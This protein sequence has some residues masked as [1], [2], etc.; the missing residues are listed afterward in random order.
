MAEARLRIGDKFDPPAEILAGGVTGVIGRRGTGKSGYV[1]RCLEELSRVGIPFVAFDPAG[2][3]WGIRSSADGKSEGYPVLVI[4]GNNG[5]IPLDK[6]K[7]AALAHKVVELNISVVIDISAYGAETYRTFVTAFCN[8]LFQINDTLRH[9]VLEEAPDLVPQ[10]L[11]PDQKKCYAAVERLVR[12]GRNKDLGVTLVSQRAATVNKDVLSQ[13]SCLVVFGLISPQDRKALREWVEAN[14]DAAMLKEFYDGLASLKT[15]EAWA[16]WPDREMFKRF[17]TTD[18]V[19]FHPDKSNLRRRGL[20]GMR[21]V[22]TDMK[23]VATRLAESLKIPVIDEKDLSAMNAALNAARHEAETL[24]KRLAA[25]DDGAAR[26]SAANLAAALAATERE[27]RARAVRIV[28]T[29]KN[30]RTGSVLGLGHALDTAI[31]EAEGMLAARPAVPPVG[32]VA[33]TRPATP[34]PVTWDGPANPASS[35]DLPSL[36]SEEG[37][38]NPARTGP[39]QRVLKTIKRLNLLGMHRPSRDRVAVWAGYTPGTGTISTVFSRLKGGGYIGFEGAGVFLTPVGEQEAGEVE[40]ITGVAELH[41]TVQESVRR[42][43]YAASWR[44]LDHLIK[45]YPAIVDRA[46]LAEATGYTPDTGTF[47]TVLSR[48]RG[49]GLAERADGG[50]KATEILFLDS[51]GTR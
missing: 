38:K 43:K 17:R 42:T 40:P 46:I 21:P 5:D 36:L 6:D 4:G 25:A 9:I 2:V 23:A 20:V 10:R 24:R 47:S 1:K 28:A 13:L 7:G 39:G 16:W 29:L 12:V 49:M 30:A 27:T 50:E 41:A 44:V 45:A 18:M 51:E 11:Y 15:R 26:A 34:G 14:A 19:S 8:T 22:Y 32:F 33:P 35:R 3:L 48:L 37:A 31:G